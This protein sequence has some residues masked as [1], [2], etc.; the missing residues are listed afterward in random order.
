MTNELKSNMAK[1]QVKKKPEKKWK[2]I[3]D[4]DGDTYGYYGG[5]TAVLKEDID[6]DTY[7]K[8][9]KRNPWWA[10]DEKCIFSCELDA[11]ESCC[12]FPLLRDCATNPYIDKLTEEVKED[13]VKA[14]KKWLT[15]KKGDIL[16][17]KGYFMAYL[18]DTKEYK[19]AAE[20]LEAAG[21][22]KG[23]ALK[24]NH[25][26]YKNVRWEWFDGKKVKREKT[27]STLPI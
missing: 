14:F 3:I 16:K 27:L 11:E 23:V 5:F 22:V 12:G 2:L 8:Q 6:E 15:S 20:I 19:Q 17:K 24:S 18:P 25:G 7:E 26:N 13:V 9:R 1:K 10:P 21:F 4:P